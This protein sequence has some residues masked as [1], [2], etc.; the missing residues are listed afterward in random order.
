MTV[1]LIMCTIA[2]GALN[3]AVPVANL[4]CLTLKTHAGEGP[5]PKIKFREIRVIR[6]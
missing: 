5:C 2:Y 1:R 4:V 3:H 6:D